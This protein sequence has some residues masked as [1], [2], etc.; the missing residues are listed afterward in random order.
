MIF[1]SS[2]GGSELIE[3][4]SLSA[5]QSVLIEDVLLSI[6]GVE[7]GSGQLMLEKGGVLIFTRTWND[8]PAGTF[9]QFIGPLPLEESVSSAH[10][11]G[12]AAGAI[13]SD[14]Y[15]TNVG[16]TESSG[17]FGVF[18]VSLLDGTG[19]EICRQQVGLGP[20]EGWQ[21]DLRSF[22]CGRLASGTVRIEHVSGEGHVFGYIS[23][24]DNATGDP[25]YVPVSAGPGN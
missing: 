4:M 3:R 23:V 1:R 16:M 6:F 5:G 9:G 12:Y 25:T 19:V 17:K 8:H 22:G 11:R 10:D 13:I 21:S 2:Q 18:A 14:A 15:R 7:N 20:W 24:V